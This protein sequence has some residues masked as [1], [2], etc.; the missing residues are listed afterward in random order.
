VCVPLAIACLLG[1]PWLTGCGSKF[2]A[3]RP[4][5]GIVLYHGKPVQGATVLFSRGSRNIAA[6]EV[7]MGKSNAEG[8]FTLT[9][10][11]G[12]ESDAKGAPVGQYEVT[13]SKH[14]P[15]KGV[16]ESQYQAMV[17]AANKLGATGVAVAPDK[18][19]PPLVEMFPEQYSVVGKSKLT[20]DV[21]AQGPNDFQFN[22]E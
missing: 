9:T 20:A 19:P 3:T 11:F 22:L 7:A 10:H 18:Q 21:T 8:R 5:T 4:V 15:P 12:S 17:D 6:G 2:P 16:S 1:M 13:V 14:I